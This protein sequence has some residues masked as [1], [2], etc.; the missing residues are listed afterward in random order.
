MPPGRRDAATLRK[1]DTVR[2]PAHAGDGDTDDHRRPA[3]HIRDAPGGARNAAR[4]A[5]PA[6]RAID[7]ADQC[8]RS[9]GEEC[10]G[11]TRL[12]RP[13]TRR[14]AAFVQ[15]GADPK[16]GSAR[17][18]AGAGLD[19]RRARRISRHGRTREQQIGETRSQLLQ[20]GAERADQISDQLDKARVELAAV[21]ERVQVSR[22]V[23]HALR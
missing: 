17:A 18:R 7:V 6:H 19:R 13:G 20:L 11:A 1:A 15:Q 12:H 5:G 9:A 2:A 16:A 3:H 14:Q 23:L 22:D 21:T 4:G 10:C 8:A